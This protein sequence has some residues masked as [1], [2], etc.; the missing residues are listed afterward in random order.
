MSRKTSL[1][2][3][4]V[5]VMA[6]LAATAAAAGA[7]PHTARVCQRP[8]PGRNCTTFMAAL[9]DPGVNHI[10]LVEDIVLDPEEWAPWTRSGGPH[11]VLNR[12]I[13][14]EGAT[15]DTNIDHK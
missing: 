9:L 15:W 14:V 12:S 2:L 1:R 3:A 8:Q 7:D 13:V 11:I 5:A 4:C 6:A 10:L